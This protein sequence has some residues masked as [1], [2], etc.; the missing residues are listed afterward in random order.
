VPLLDPRAP[1]VVFTH[2]PLGSIGWMTPLNAADALNRFSGL[3]LRAA[4]CGHF[5][6]CTARE[7]LSAA[8]VTTACCSRLRHNHDGTL[9]EGWLV[10]TAHADGRLERRFVEFEPA[11]LAEAPAP[12]PLGPAAPRPDAP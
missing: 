6:G 7:H 1:T 4:L 10:C 5:H 3:D 2:F 8:L 11:R 9:P 12:I